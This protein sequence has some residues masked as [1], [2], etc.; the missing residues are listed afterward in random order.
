M[1]PGLQPLNLL[2]CLLNQRVRIWAT[3]YL[4]QYNPF[5]DI[6]NLQNMALLPQ[7]QTT[8]DAC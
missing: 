5:P 3:S 7:P 8:Q 4:G 6:L 2:V 1:A